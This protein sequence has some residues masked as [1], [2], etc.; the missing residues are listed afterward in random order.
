MSTADYCYT[1]AMLPPD[2][3]GCHH[4]GP[5]WW[6]GNMRMCGLVQH[7]ELDG[8]LHLVNSISGGGE[9]PAVITCN[10]LINNLWADARI[11]DALVVFDVMLLRRRAFGR[12]VWSPTASS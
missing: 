3:Q 4:R 11:L 9:H 5:E 2:G 1:A 12:L 10:I 6:Q 7:S 8:A